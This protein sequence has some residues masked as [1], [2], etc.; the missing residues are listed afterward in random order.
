MGSTDVAQASIDDLSVAQ[1]HDRL[2]RV[3][4][5]LR[6]GRKRSHHEFDR[7]DLA[8]REL[9]FLAVDPQD[10]STGSHVDQLAARPFAVPEGE[11]CRLLRSN[12]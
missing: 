7:R 9:P 12:G 6:V 10:E 4:L 5:G 1:Q 2:P 8:G 11:G 3:D